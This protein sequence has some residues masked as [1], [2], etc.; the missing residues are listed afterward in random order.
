MKKIIAISIAVVMLAAFV[1]CGA[2]TEGATATTKTGLGMVSNVQI[3]AAGENDGS[4]QVDTTSCAVTIDDNGVIVGINF[5]VTEGKTKFGADGSA[6]TEPEK[7]IKS[8]KELGADY[9]MKVASGIKKEA[10]EQIAALEEYCIG[11]KVEDVMKM[12]L[13]EKGSPADLATSC[14]ISVGDYLLAL[15]KAVKNAK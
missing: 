15:E 3:T 12:Q 14:T 11:K 6:K 1:G 9:G 13:T 10:N 2:K 8:K 5:D 7:N 4:T